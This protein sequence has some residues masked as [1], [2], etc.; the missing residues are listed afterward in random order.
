MTKP[1][2]EILDEAAIVD[3]ERALER[4]GPVDLMQLP[5]MLGGA[6]ADLRT[7]AEH[8]TT[9]PS[10]LVN[11]EH[12]NERVASLDEEVKQMRAAVET[13]GGDVVALGGGIDRL[14]THL[15]DVSRVTHPLRRIGRRRKPE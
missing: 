15:D 2:P 1:A 4:R 6:L 7:I 11:L 5:R 3:D 8:I 13:M 10:L 9:L 12:I 14:E